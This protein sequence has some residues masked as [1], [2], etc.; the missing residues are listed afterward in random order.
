VLLDLRFRNTGQVGVLPLREEFYHGSCPLDTVAD[1]ESFE[2]IFSTE[3]SV[4]EVINMA[5]RA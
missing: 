2:V 4:V 1:S 3:I 5:E